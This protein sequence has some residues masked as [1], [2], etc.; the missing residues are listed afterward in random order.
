MFH[1]NKPFKLKLL[2]AYNPQPNYTPPSW[3][4]LPRYDS[5]PPIPFNE[6]VQ[7]N[8]WFISNW[9]IMHA[10][11]K[12]KFVIILVNN[13]CIHPESLTF[14]S[15]LPPKQCALKPCSR[16]Y[17]W[18]H[19]SV[20]MQFFIMRAITNAGCS[21]VYQQWQHCMYTVSIYRTFTFRRGIKGKGCERGNNR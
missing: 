1:Y 3:F 2:G 8:T 13:W 15:I 19:W 5:L 16:C 21:I 10:L 11:K 9:W 6:I 20:G 18:F 17:W 4:W 7:E 12:Y 14:S